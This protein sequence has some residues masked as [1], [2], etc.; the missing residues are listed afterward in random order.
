MSNSA[1]DP[2][3]QAA[4]RL[5]AAVEHLAT[6]VSRSRAAAD[7]VPRAEVAALATRLE[8]TMAR[9]KAALRDQD[10]G[11]DEEED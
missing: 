8:A 3:M 2:M 1:T 4:A 7:S 10:V 9:L 5:E 6:A 11:D